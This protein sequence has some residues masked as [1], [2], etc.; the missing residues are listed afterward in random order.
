M[1]RSARPA[2]NWCCPETIICRGS[3]VLSD[4]D[5]VGAVYIDCSPGV[6]YFIDEY[7]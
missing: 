5:R 4:S 6:T 1:M 7:G 3:A 2:P